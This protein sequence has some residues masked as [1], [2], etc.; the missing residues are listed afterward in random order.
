[1]SPGIPA[2][3]GAIGGGAIGSTGGGATGSGTNTAP[4][5]GSSSTTTAVTADQEAPR[6]YTIDQLADDLAQVLR[7]LDVTGSLTVAAHSMGGM[8]VLAYLQRPQPE[9]PVDPIG[10]VLVATAAGKLTERGLGRLLAAPGIA[11]LLSLGTHSRASA[12]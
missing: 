7:V 1:M 4:V 3:A 9:R 10:L 11:R 8:T 5:C 6:S 2:P 12:S